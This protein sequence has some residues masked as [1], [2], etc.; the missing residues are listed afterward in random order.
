M[1]T[2]QCTTAQLAAATERTA[3]MQAKP[4]ITGRGWD[5]LTVRI[6]VVI[7]LWTLL[8]HS[9]EIIGRHKARL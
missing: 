9:D 6:E 7:E 1:P 8:N 4:M 2:T 5:N 3:N